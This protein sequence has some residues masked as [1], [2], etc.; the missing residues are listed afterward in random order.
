MTSL[1]PLQKLIILIYVFITQ[2]SKMHMVNVV[3]D[4]TYVKQKL[5]KRSRL[6]VIVS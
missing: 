1:G 6:I 2:I 4:T 3:Q 5:L